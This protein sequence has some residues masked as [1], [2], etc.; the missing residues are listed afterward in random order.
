MPMKW[1]LYWQPNSGTAINSQ[2]LTEVYQCVE[3]MN[4]TKG[5]RWKTSIT[6]YKVILRDPNA[7]AEYARDFLGISLNEQPNKHYFILRGSRVVVEADSTIL[8]IMEKLQSYKSRLSLFFEGIQYQ[9]GDFQLRVGKV[10]LSHSENLKGIVMEVEY[11][12]ISSVEKSRQIMEEFLDIWQETLSK[13]SLP[14]HFVHN[15]ANFADYGLADH[16]TSQHTAV[17]YVLVMGHLIAAVR[18]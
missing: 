2:I 15:E 11:M 12:P 18:G 1:I 8:T 14:G 17:Q 6:L 9:I 5:G 3:S 10:V 7:P 4:A 16:Y 13:K